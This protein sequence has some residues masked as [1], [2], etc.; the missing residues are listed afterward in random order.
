[1]PLGFFVILSL[2]YTFPLPLHLSDATL[3]PA[4]GLNYA[5]MANAALIAE[6]LEE[7]HGI[8]ESHRIWFPSGYTLHEG[9]LPSLLVFLF[10]DGGDLLRGLNLSL[11]LSFALAG[12][13][14]YLLAYEVTGSRPGSLVA[15]IYFGF[16]PQ[17][18]GN[19]GTYPIFHVQWLPLFFWALFRY[20]RT[21]Q[22]AW[23]VA[24]AGFFAAA[25][26]SSWYFAVFLVVGAGLWLAAYGW[27][28]RN[29]RR[30]VWSAVAIGVAGLAVA[31]LSPVA[32]LGKDGLASGGFRLVIDGSADLLSFFTPHALH[33]LFLGWSQQAQ[34]DWTGNP[35]LQ[36]NY[37]GTLSLLLCF[38][39]CYRWRQEQW[40]RGWLVVTAV[41]FFVLSLGPFL[42]VDGLKGFDVR[43]PSSHLEAVRLPFYW[44]AEV[45]PFRVT[46]AVSRYSFITTLCL[47]VFLASGVAALTSRLARPVR[48][49]IVAAALGMVVLVEFLP[50]WPTATIRPAAPS[51]FY[52]RLA[53]QTGEGSVIEL[54]FRPSA[55]RILHY[56]TLHRHKVI[57]GA[58]DKPWVRF[59]AQARRRPLL[60]RLAL[61]SSPE[62]RPEVFA[63]VFGDRWEDFAR[64]EAADLRVEYVILHLMDESIL[65]FG[66]Y[67][68]AEPLAAEVQQQLPPWFQ[69]VYEDRLVR[70]FRVTG[71]PS[72]W[73]YPILGNG[74]GRLESHGEYVDRPLLGDR[75][76]LDIRASHAGVARL[77]LDLSLILVPERTLEISLAGRR[78]LTTRLQRRRN[79]GEV[80]TVVLDSVPL[81]A[82]TNQIE[83]WTP[84]PVPTIAEVYRGNDTRPIAFLLNRV[85]V[86]YSDS[87]P[88]D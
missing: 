29:F 25:A 17:H 66:D 43:Q 83:L 67:Y 26:L 80:Q 87:P 69:M 38:V 73:V 20:G 9:L 79:P 52:S 70:A 56:S 36:M 88:A 32:L 49:Y 31:P 15:G 41:G 58:V 7:G 55:Y 51:E 68:V 8:L 82:G 59:E 40:L 27:A 78:L 46:R 21:G 39:G 61:A 19:L 33:W 13:A 64:A 54:P 37:L 84:E 50:L 23:L 16:S 81:V 74:W 85:D 5:V 62:P 22:P 53:Q 6:A 30:T 14:A 10:G 34:A 18:Y 65:S 75:A 60:R 86:A 48:K 77:E 11:L 47:S 3:S 24:V 42:A 57:G 4:L 71:L 1:M 35:S 12:W 2:V 44:L 63:D 72:R 28:S 45:F 76:T